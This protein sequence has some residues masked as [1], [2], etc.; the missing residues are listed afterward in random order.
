MTRG[1]PAFKQI[2]ISRALRAAKAAG[3]EVTR[4]ELDAVSGK[5]VIT[6]GAA[7]KEAVSDLDK[8]LAQHAD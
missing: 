1:Q 5:I 2:D 6:T 8:W 4:I 3:V 7:A